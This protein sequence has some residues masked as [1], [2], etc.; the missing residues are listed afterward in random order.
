M[1]LSEGVLSVPVL[2]GG[3]VLAAAGVGMGIKKLDAEHIAGAGLLAAGFFVASL[4]HVPIGPSSAHLVLNGLVGLILGWTAFPVIFVALVLQGVFL[5]FGGITTLG[6]NT[7]V[8]ALPAV[9]VHYAC[10]PFLGRK[11]AVAAAAGF[12]CGAGAVAGG[13]VL[14]AA[15][16]MATGQHFWQ[17]AGLILA[18]HVPVMIVE[19]LVTLFCVEFL[20]KVMP[21]MLPG[22][23][24]KDGPSNKGEP[25]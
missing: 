16:L 10:K 5:Q 9:A 23:S 22:L 25:G 17:V 7:V 2:A 12:G 18:A 11:S 6:V 15:A 21:E 19:G 3:A 24:R 20:Q 13:A 14:V 1:H 4:I 8:M